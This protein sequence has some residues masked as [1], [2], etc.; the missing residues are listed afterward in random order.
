MALMTKRVLSIIPARSG[1]KGFPRKNIAQLAG[2]PLIV[3]TIEASRKS[4]FIS[5]TVVSSDD[6]EILDISAENGAEIIRRPDNLATDASKSESVV[7]HAIN[8]FQSKGEEFDIVILLQ[9]TSPLRDH[10]DIDNAFKIMN[11][12]C[13]SA[14]ISVSEINNKILKTFI[15][16]SN[17]F[18]KGVSNNNYPFM[19]RQDLPSVFM[20]NGAI[21]I[22]K[23]DNFIKNNSFYTNNTLPFIM[24]NDSSSDID[25]KEDLI[26]VE[27]FFPYEK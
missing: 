1:S 27:K 8:Y 21:F 19:R 6:Q 16:D 10:K 11:L 5:K 2:K 24:D 7:S 22:V 12:A 26:L 17:G 3:W 4:K 25:T 18:L 23:I 9:P 14:V 20:P 15:K 13:T